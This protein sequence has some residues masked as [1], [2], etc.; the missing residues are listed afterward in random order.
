[1]ISLP[2][3]NMP[4]YFTRM[5]QVNM[6]SGGENFRKL[7]DSIYKNQSLYALCSIAFKDI[8]QD[9][10]LEKI[11]N[12]LGWYG[13]RDR[14][15]SLFIY[16]QRHGHYPLQYKIN[17]ANLIIHYEKKIQNFTTDG[18]S[19]G[20]LLGFYVE[21]ANYA[22]EVGDIDQGKKNSLQIL[23]LTFDKIDQ[24][25][26]SAKLFQGRTVRIDFLLLLL[27]HFHLFL[28]EEQTLKLMTEGKEYNDIF[29]LLELSDQKNLILNMMSYGSSIGDLDFFVG[30]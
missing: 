8:D 1:M 6:Q 20:F 3:I 19:R 15:A 9:L 5:L 10:R 26:K 25:I 7:Q 21:M 14:L 11:I 27:A 2:F 12:A 17:Y 22:I 4:D 29:P 13:F 30:K 23:N 24:L 28:G 16:Y 18:Y